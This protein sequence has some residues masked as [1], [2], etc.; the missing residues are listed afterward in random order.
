MYSGEVSVSE[1]Q[2][3]PLVHAAKSLCIKG[4]LDVPVPNHETPESNLQPPPLKKPKMNPVR[5][6]AEENK[7]KKTPTSVP[8]ISVEDENSYEDEDE[9]GENMSSDSEFINQNVRFAIFYSKH[10]IVLSNT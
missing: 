4:L 7:P 3:I 2:I 6:A 1:D 10:L 8:V 5:T 9:G